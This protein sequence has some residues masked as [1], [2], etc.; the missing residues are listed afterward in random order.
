MALQHWCI[1]SRL[2]GTSPSTIFLSSLHQ[3]DVTWIS[4]HNRCGFVFCHRLP[5]PID[6]TLSPCHRYVFVFN[7]TRLLREFH[8]VVFT[9]Y[10]RNSNRFNTYPHNMRAFLLGST[11]WNIHATSNG[12]N[13]FSPSKV[14]RR[15]YMCVMREFPLHLPSLITGMDAQVW[16]PGT[17]NCRHDEMIRGYFL[18]SS[19][20]IRALYYMVLMFGTLNT[21]TGTL[22][23][24]WAQPVKF[25]PSKK[26]YVYVGH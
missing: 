7:L 4:P 20:H 1:S 22:I 2:H 9:R 24:L 8:P 6:S 19:R 25:K 5:S 12:K 26:I 23:V 16:S 11:L 18:V 15:R 3:V 13:A 10:C 14:H 17:C 21:P